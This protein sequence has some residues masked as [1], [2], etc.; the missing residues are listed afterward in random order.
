MQR[1]SR[2]PNSPSCIPHNQVQKCQFSLR[3]ADNKNC[4]CMHYRC[5]SISFHEE[6][7]S[8]RSPH[9]SLGEVDINLLG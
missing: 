8:K 9:F 4:L 6:A 7:C 2:R 3:A 1:P 5:C